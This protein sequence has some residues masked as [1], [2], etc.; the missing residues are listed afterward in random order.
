MPLDLLNLPR[1]S[2]IAIL[3][4]LDD[5]SLLRLR[6]DLQTHDITLEFGFNERRDC[7]MWKMC[8]IRIPNSASLELIEKIYP[9]HVAFQF[10]ALTRVNCKFLNRVADLVE[11]IRLELDKTCRVFAAI[12]NDVLN[13]K[14]NRLEIE[15][16]YRNASISLAEA[17]RMIKFFH[18]KQ[19]PIRFVAGANAQPCNVQI[20]LYNMSVEHMGEWSGTRITIKHLHYE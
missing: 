20:G 14:C 7:S 2:I 11:S 9:T 18:H 17:E 15:V 1:N 13:R 19:Q 8:S 4:F 3:K 10:Y 5:R 6:E 16:P 12:A